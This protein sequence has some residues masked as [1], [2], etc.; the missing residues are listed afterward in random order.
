MVFDYQQHLFVLSKEKEID[1]ACNNL[2]ANILS[3]LLIE[4]CIAIGGK[5]HQIQD[6]PV[7]YQHCLQA[8]QLKSMF[9]LS[10]PVIHYERMYLYRIVAGM[11]DNLK[12]DILN[13]VFHEKT[14][15]IFDKEMT[16]TIDAYFQ[17]NLNVTDTA[18]AI[19]IH[20]NTLLYRIDKIH[21]HTGFDLKN[22]EDS[23][24]FKLAW[25]IRKEKQVNQKESIA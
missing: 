10:D 7:C 24:L 6:L 18:N 25:L 13:R 1:Q 21:H 5:A 22:M 8:F 9:Q 4:C 20:R 19:F 12:Q 11:D 3:D 15:E 23:W 14:V 17:N 2:A 16:R